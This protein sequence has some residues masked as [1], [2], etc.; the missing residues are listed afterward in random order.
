MLAQ[1]FTDWEVIFWDNQSDDRTASIVQG[2][3]DA[4]IRFLRAPC[5]MTLAQGRNAAM[6]RA[7]GRWIAFLD[8]DDRWF[9]D[10][11][12]RQL[13]RL[14]EHGGAGVGIVYGRTKSF[15]ARGSEGETIYRYT[16][17]PLPEGRIVQL[18]LEQGNL[19]PIVSALVSR[20]AVDA[21]GPI[22][23][24]YTFAE[25]YYLF[26]AIAER[27]DV[28]CVQTPCCEYRVHPDSATARN[29]LTGLREGLIVLEQFAH[30]LSAD[31]LGR[32]RAI[33]GTLI[34]IELVRSEGRLG[35]GLMHGLR[36]GSPTFLLGGMARTL[37]RRWIYR[38]RPYS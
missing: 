3:D 24:T 28:L 9:P 4:R 13:A 18:L 10:K 17:R 31:A 29:K 5:R 33:L 11:L 1:T 34:A 27:F 6:A 30:L 38:Q 26:T 19:I 20:A 36:H 12:E 14:A 7:S 8:C 2:M 22:P 25:D 21:V 23:E 32:R 15:S 35:A 16:G 37:I